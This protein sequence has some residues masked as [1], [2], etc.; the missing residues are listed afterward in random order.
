MFSFLFTYKHS[1]K[2][3]YFN[4]NMLGFGFFYILTHIVFFTVLA[5]TMFGMV[6]T[7]ST[8][9]LLCQYGFDNGWG[10]IFYITGYFV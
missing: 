10:S 1:I 2:G 9:G 8:S 3:L 4:R 5:G 7:F 6:G